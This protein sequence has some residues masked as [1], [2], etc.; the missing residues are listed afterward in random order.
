MRLVVRAAEVTRRGAAHRHHVARTSTPASTTVRRRSTSSTASSMAAREVTVPTTLNV[1]A[2]DLLHPELYRGDP[3]TV[4]RGRLLMDHYRALGA[5]PTFTCAPYQLADARP[6]LGEQVA[7]GES[8][9][10]AFC[11]SRPRR[12]NEPLRR[13]PRHRGRDHR[14]RPGRRPPS[15]RCAPRHPRAP[16][17]RRRPGR[18]CATSDALAP[19][20]GLVL[21]RRAGSGGGRD[22]RAA[23]RPVRGPAQGDRRRRGLLRIGGDVPRR[24][25]DAGGA[26]AR[27]GHPRRRGARRGRHARGAARGPRR[28]DERRRSVAGGDLP[29]HAARVARRARAVR[30]AAR[31]PPRRL[32]DRV[33]GLHRPRRP[34]SG[35][36]ARDRRA[37]PGGRRRAARRHLQL[38][39]ADPAARRLAR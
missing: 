21:G 13:L 28:A 14:P 35:R 6:A 27:G 23:G 7:W 20:L 24:R 5:R 3:A 33:P 12:A 32:A 16:A 26:D 19:V 39:R 17:R 4:E 31:R 36:R 2:V 38:H 37:S 10:I 8:N 30:D 15:D 9:A 25:L 18:S 1:G 11:N 34:G 22:R 29:R